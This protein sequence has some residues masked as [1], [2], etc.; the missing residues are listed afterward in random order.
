VGSGA[1]LLP[2]GS[3]ASAFGTLNVGGLTF[4]PGSIVGLDFGSVTQ[5]LINVSGSNALNV[6][7]GGVKLY[8]ADG[9][10]PLGLGTY[11]LADYS[12]VVAGFPSNLLVLNPVAGYVYAFTASGGSLNVNVSGTNVWNGMG[13]SP[14]NWSNGANWSASQAPASG[15]P[16]VFD[17]SVGTANNNDMTSFLA[18]GITFNAT[19]GA[20]NLSGNSIQLAGPIVNNSPATQTIGLN[21]QLAGANQPI[22]AAVGNIVL[23]GV[24]SDGGAGLGIALS[25]SGTV[26]LTGNN[27][28]SGPTIV[29]SGVLILGASGGPAISGNLTV[30]GGSAQFASSNQIAA[31]GNVSVSGGLLVVAVANPFSG[32]AS[33]SAGTLDVQNSLGLQN[34]TVNL[35]GGNLVFDQLAASHA[36]TFG[37]LAGS[38]NLSLLDNGGSSVALTIGNNNANATYSGVLSGGTA[39]SL[40]IVGSGMSTLSGGNTFSGPTLISS[41]TLQIGTA[42]ALQNSLLNTNGAGTL[43]FSVASANLG[44]LSGSG[45]ITLPSSF[46]GTLTLAT[47]AGTS[48]TYSG[49]LN[50]LSANLGMTK[51]GAGAQ[52]LSGSVTLGS[53]Q[54]SIS[55]GTLNLNGSM[56]SSGHL[57]VDASV[58]NVNPGATYTLAGANQLT[59]GDNGTTSLLNIAGTVN[60]ESTNGNDTLIGQ[61]SNSNATI[62]ILSGG[63]LN[64]S[65]VGSTGSGIRL[66]NKGNDSSNPFGT[67]TM[68]P[69][70]QFNLDSSSSS[71]ILA[72]N[73]G[74]SGVVTGTLNLNGGTLT[75]ARK[76]TNG[77]G[78]SILNF[79]GGVLVSNT[80]SNSFIGLG[81]NASSRAYIRTGGLI[82]DTNGFTITTTAA[83]SHNSAD[84]ASDGG[85]TLNDPTVTPGTLTLAGSNNYT[86]RTYVQA[87][88]LALGANGSINYSPLISLANGTTFN[89]TAK[90]STYSLLGSPVAQTLSGTGNFSV[91]GTMTAGS[92]ST[93]L[94]GGAT[95]SGTLNVTALNLS[96][97]SILKFDLGSGQDLVNVLS[98]GG[99]AINGGSIGLYQSNGSSTFSTPGT[100]PL[101]DYIGAAPAVGNLSVLNPSGSDVYSF[102][103]NNGVLSVTIAA[104]GTWSGGG[105]PN[106]VWSNSANWAG[107]LVPPSGNAITF[108]GTLGLSNTNDL[109]NFNVAGLTFSSSAG[110]FNISGNSIQ[111]SG[112]VVNSSTA[113]QTLGLNIGL[114]GGSQNFNAAAGNIVVNGAISD[115]G[116]GYGVGKTGTG[117]LT[118]N[119]NNTYNG[120]TVVSN[121]VLQAGNNHAL[122]NGQ[123]GLNGGQFSSSGAGSLAFAN[124][125]SL[126]GSATLG[127]PVNNGG[128]SF[129]G[130]GAI[131]VANPQLTVNSPVTL[132]GAISDGGNGWTILGP[133]LLALTGPNNIT[134]ATVVSGGTLQ[135]N[136]SAGTA[137]GGNL[138]VSGGAVQIL[139]SNQTASTSN[140]G[141]SAG[142]LSVGANNNSING[143]QLTGGT[144]SGTSGLLT[145]TGTSAFD[146]QNGTEG[147]ILDGGV[148]LNKTTSGTVVLS[149]ANTF[150]GP[151]SVTAGTL[152]VAHPLALQNTTVSVTSNGALGF[153]AG[154]TSPTFGGLGGGSNIALTTAASQAVALTVGG[155]NANTTY[156]GALS[157]P[158]SLIKQGVGTLTLGATSTYSGAT[159]ITG[160]VLQ[161][162]NPIPTAPVMANLI[163]WL[164]PSKSSN[165]TLTGGQFTTL[166]DL[167]GNGNYFTGAFGSFGG[168]TTTTINGLTAMHF[169]TSTFNGIAGAEGNIMTLGNATSPEQ[170]FMIDKVGSNNDN[171][172]GIWGNVHGSQ[173][174]GGN[175]GIRENNSSNAWN[176][177]SGSGGDYATPSSGSMSI[178]GVPVATNAD[179]AFTPGSAQLLEAT[180]P[181]AGSFAETGLGAYVTYPFGFGQYYNGAIGEVLAYSTT[182][183]ALQQ[184]QNTAYLMYKWLGIS[185]SLTPINVL[186]VATPV[187]IS[188][189]GILD[190]TNGMQTIS[191][192]SSTDGMGSQLLM[193]SGQLTIAGNSSTTFDGVI[194]GAGGSFAVQGGSI[195]LTNFNTYSG[196]T[197]IN[198]GT[199]QLGTGAAGQDGAIAN[200]SGV[201]LGN[202][203]ALIYNV[204]SSQN[205]TYPITGNGSVTM[206]GPGT[207]TLSNSNNS[208]FGGTNVFAGLVAIAP[209]SAALPYGK[210][211]VSNGSLDLEGNSPTVVSLNGN[212]TI[213]NGTSGPA[214][215][216]VLS[217]EA[218][219]AF[220]G[221]IQDGAYGGDTV[222]LE[223]DGGTLILSGTNTY[224]GG[225]LVDGGTLVLDSASA[226]ADGT[227]L[228]VG[229]GASSLF[230]PAAAGPAVGISSAAEGV[231]VVPEPGAWPLLAAALWS[232]AGHRVLRVGRSFSRRPRASGAQQLK[233]CK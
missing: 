173:N 59:I 101:M 154:T 197:A 140:V 226:I 164:D 136:S 11:T 126:G 207:L 109:T 182:L 193:G 223:L 227:S 176:Y 144:I 178:N 10:S 147:A 230:A 113:T 174:Q 185:T 183:T 20:F 58:F 90:N 85:L 191:S 217:V 125:I 99:L 81:S 68:D 8:Q 222:G 186:P 40:T 54:T 172:D 104:P 190:M 37:S 33:I 45:N 232:V 76:I 184:Q 110:A 225:T 208:Y 77:G 79:N 14:F 150:T 195:V 114:A 189:G 216:A 214:N 209:G 188:G 27:T 3:G 66:G 38:S 199:L 120:S 156:A 93:I 141:V 215:P 65:G 19:A 211:N 130:T 168:P 151:T 116:A 161:L 231:T 165:Y 88:N 187:T 83:F 228:I 97:G 204:F 96:I 158:G 43:A 153:A 49:N 142:L 25:G 121:G 62:H 127:D 78:V 26:T 157:G 48:P 4:Q 138:T 171:N 44:G 162:V 128:L 53:N 92:A 219:G 132:N 202:N 1:T 148:G 16:L 100:Y 98:S 6:A 2:G 52:T 105:G 74:G 23:G 47:T 24:I 160:G 123:L 63:V 82:F 87:G 192:L 41:G 155:N 139:Q 89:V 86:G 75:T 18:A 206:S 7:G 221:N 12:G 72:N 61:D 205:A 122:G 112:G 124:G 117:T 13:G 212:G 9:M 169:A 198:G 64:I 103:A 60:I 163:Y 21:M 67:V 233:R 106:F 91:V 224:S 50:G 29:N 57:V 118:L 194:S 145:S 203:G 159:N 107:S 181:T 84:G 80:S 152:V 95:S 131:T 218:G 31:T 177:A 51:N 70:S 170:V 135:L 137:V 166:N 229:D 15:S 28:Y 133:S 180:N 108:T 36:F 210:L 73:G 201:N 34:S 213:F 71:F 111:L 55:A 69:G 175:F 119:G 149:N 134:G 146:M 17:G 94:P 35:T 196:S 115:G 22:N 39:T 179:G 167:S 5:G 32:M 30:T 42:L 46:T 220:S 129:A 200:T 143:L 56:T 102:G